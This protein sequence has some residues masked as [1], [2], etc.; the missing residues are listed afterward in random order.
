MAQ[1]NLSGA[2]ATNASLRAHLASARETNAYLQERLEDEIAARKKDAEVARQREQTHVKTATVLRGQIDDL[3]TQ[4]AARVDQVRP[5]LPRCRVSAHLLTP[6]PS[7]LPCLSC[8]R[9][10]ADDGPAAGG[11]HP[12]P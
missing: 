7:L 10:S 9:A 1:T 6:H 12:A 3:E 4:L 2:T 5:G 8:A 11:G